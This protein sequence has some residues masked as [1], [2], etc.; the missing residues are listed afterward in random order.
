MKGWRWAPLL[1][2][3][4]YMLRLLLLPPALLLSL[5]H[6][7][8]SRFGCTSTV[9]AGMAGLLGQLPTRVRAPSTLQR[10][11]QQ[12]SNRPHPGDRARQ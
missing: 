4:A 8:C 11:Y 5:R 9:C 7:R 10:W 1:L 3:S 6:T 12:G 2:L